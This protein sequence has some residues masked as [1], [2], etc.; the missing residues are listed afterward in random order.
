MHTPTSR[1]TTAKK[2]LNRTPR[3]MV[4]AV[5]SSANPTY[6][7]SDNKNDKEE[8]NKVL[9]SRVKYSSGE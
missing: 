1:A 8:E 4:R 3:V 9:I 2:A 7:P 5:C 6:P